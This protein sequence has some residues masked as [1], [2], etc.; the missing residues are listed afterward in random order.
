[1]D[2]KGTAYGSFLNSAEQIMQE[3]ML[4]VTNGS[5]DKLAWRG[6]EM[7]EHFRLVWKND[8]NLLKKIFPMFDSEVGFTSFMLYLANFLVDILRIT[9][10]HTAVT[11]GK[12]GFSH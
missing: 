8:G 9:V 12:K 7:R 3:Q 1:M 10:V 4:S 11:T 6:A 2:G 5:C